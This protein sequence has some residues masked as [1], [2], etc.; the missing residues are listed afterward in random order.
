M[1]SK[2]YSFI[3]VSLRQEEILKFEWND[4]DLTEEERAEIQDFLERVKELGVENAFFDE[5]ALVFI[6]GTHVPIPEKVRVIR[7]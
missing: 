6:D 5:E 4:Q 3:L 7:D 1:V 2:E